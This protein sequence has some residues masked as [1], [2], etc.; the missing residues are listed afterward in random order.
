M[1]LSAGTKLGSYEV[2]SA[3]GSGG[4]GEV[5][6]ARDTKLGRDVAIKVLPEAFAH[7][8]DYLSRFQGEA[9]ILA[10]LNHPNIAAI[11]GL[12]ENLG[13]SYLVMELVPGD[14]LAERIKRGGAIPV[15]ETL[16]IARQMAEALE[17][18]HEKGIIH[19]DLKPANVKVTPDGKVKLLDFG[20]AKAVAGEGSSEGSSQD[21]AN[22]PTMTRAATM[23]G[24]ILGTA[25]YMSPEQ[26]RG[27]PVDKRAD[28]WAFGVV[29]Y[30]M[31]TGQQVFAG[32]TVS[33]TLA[34]VLRHD[35]D[36]GPVPAR[37][38]RLLRW[39]LEKDP[40]KR[41]R[42]IAD[43]MA[44]VD[45]EPDQR[46][47]HGTS[48]AIPVWPWAVAATACLIAAGLAL[49]L[50]RGKPP[51]AQESYRLT[52]RLPENVTFS[53]SAA[54]A[55]SPDGRRVA[56]PAVGPDGRTSVWVQDMDGEQARALP[57]ADP[58]IDSPPFFWSPDSRYLVFLSDSKIR[59]VDVLGG[60]TQDICDRTVLPVG[61][62]WNRDGVIITG[63]ISTG[64]LR[65]PAEGGPLVSLTVLDLTR[66]E[67]EHELP[68]FLPDGRHF[69]YFINSTDPENSG[70][71]VGSLDDPPERQNKKR[72]LATRFGATYVP[73]DNSGAGHLLFL[74]D[75]VLMAQS[76]NADK[77]ELLGDP[78]PVADRVGS[79]FETGHF[80]VTPTVLV[81]RGQASAPDFQLTWFDTLGK[82]VGKVGDPGGMLT[83]RLSPNG[84]LVAFEKFAA[85][86]FNGDVWLLDLRRNSSTRFTFGPGSSQNPVWS[87]DG[88]EIV[89]SSIRDGALDL[90]RK[91]VDG[92]RAEQL[93]LRTS[94][95]KQAYSWS[96]DGRFLL[97]GAGRNFGSGQ[98]WVLPMRGEPNPIPFSH[99]RFDERDGEF[100]PDGRWVAYESNE[101]GQ[102]EIYV[103]AF[104][105]D[106]VAS[107]T[108]GKWMISKDGGMFPRW[109]S[110]GRE[111]VYISLD[112][113]AIMSVTV[114]TGHVF[115]PGVPR[116]LIKIPADRGNSSGVA[117]TP[118]LKRFLMPV[119][120]EA[121][122][123]QSFTVV[124]NWAAAL[125]K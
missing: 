93:L 69:L 97:Y 48:N 91:P 6:H 95:D 82:V 117:P 5:Y 84:S 39:C 31:L 90:Y 83:P 116:Q 36:Y 108:G 81:Y 118:D 13:I 121:K 119:A 85:N 104:S 27:K 40:K 67:T 10:S 3:I 52:V 29:L 63:S 109:S 80:S 89:F 65:V 110:D 37:M 45:E 105:G 51:T 58:S 123:P 78:S 77:F 56:F 47:S 22:S 28:I 14:T 4:M 107:Q 73:S 60:A 32:A 23:Q 43:G 70:I 33:D 61:G 106:A 88:S 87:P 86:M 41:L 30:E 1:P 26:A 2:L 17:A 20:L 19:R 76:F 125:K 100:S 8:L 68:S 59:K 44:I 66:H 42:D 11:Y 46:V 112:R 113:T 99:S 94:D 7:D 114:D 75:G 57:G 62:S 101:T 38:Q 16:A 122:A 115:R 34:A 72:L 50:F 103:R 102:Y 24:V 21:I 49:V 55:L 124:L 18:A 64:L 120:V 74:V 25:A 15:D 35:P 12:E 79:A 92:S 9:K 53:P 71:Y 54:L 96:R 111:L 98:M